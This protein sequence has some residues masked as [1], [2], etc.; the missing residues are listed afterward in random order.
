MPKLYLAPLGVLLFVSS[1]LRADSAVENMTLHQMI[2][3]GRESFVNR[4]SGCHGKDA[5]GNGPAAIMLN[6]K[7]RN[8][9]SGSFKF[10]STSSGVLP[11]VED[12]LRTLEQGI[13]GSA[14]PPFRELPT[15]EKLS[16]VMYIRSLRPEFRETK[17]DQV[18][19]QLVSMPKEIFASK[20][21]LITAAKR[22][23]IN[24]QKACINCHGESGAGDGPSAADL[25]DSDNQ[26]IRPA[27]LRLPQVKSGKTGKDLFRVISTGLDG[28]PMP[29]F[30]S[31]YKPNE[32]WDL[33]AYIYFLRGQEARIYTE[34][35]T[36]K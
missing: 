16:L 12:L 19:I 30:E 5:D 36:L 28:S 18:S 35:D 3:T 8:L 17:A 2:N 21:G 15:Q 24:Y 10:R 11:T 23:L 33:V 20:T 27:N 22:G 1:F 6:P 34:K 7:P 31:M 25:T 29:G 14:M 13:P 4:C 9:V 32:V 26:P